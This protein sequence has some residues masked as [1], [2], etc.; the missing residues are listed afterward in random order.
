MES[1][2]IFSAEQGQIYLDKLRE[3]LHF[4]LILMAFQ[5]HRFLEI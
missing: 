2:H 1:K 5:A 3:R 4:C